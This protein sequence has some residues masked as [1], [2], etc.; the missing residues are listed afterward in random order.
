MAHAALKRA[1]VEDTV[2]DLITLGLVTMDEDGRLRPTELGERMLLLD[3]TQ[4][5][6]RAIPGAQVLEL[7]P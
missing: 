7:L 4:T 2:M 6:K 5:V 3:F 1:Q